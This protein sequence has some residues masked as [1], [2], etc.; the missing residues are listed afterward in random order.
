MSVSVVQMGP[1]HLAGVV[2]LQRSCFPPPFPEEF[3][4]RREHL[5]RH[6]L[7]YPEGQF[8]ALDEAGRVVGSASACRIPED[9]WRAH[10]PWE[11]TLGGFFFEGFDRNGSTLYGADISVHPEH[12]GRGVGRRLYEARFD[13]VRKAGLARYG[14]ACRMPDFAAHSDEFAHP[15]EFA[16][17]VQEGRARDRTLT[18]LLRYGLRLI[19]VLEDYMLDE[20]SGNAAAL[21]EWTP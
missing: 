9:R 5:E 21:L 17:A 14:T 10:L 7:V 19:Q 6:V 4:W 13:L 11:E 20:E 3:L 2:A 16:R 12:R 1:E 8:V 15:A 18:P